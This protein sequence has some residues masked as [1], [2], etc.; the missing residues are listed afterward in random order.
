M[1]ETLLN[2]NQINPIDWVKPADWIDIRSGAL[3]NS[4]YFLVGHSADYTTYPTFTVRASVSSSGTYDVFVDGVKQASAV[5]SGTTTTLTWSTLALTTGYD[6]TY[7]AALRTHIVRVTPTSSS[8]TLTAIN[9]AEDSTYTSKG[10]L[11]IHFSITNRIE[12]SKLC[13]DEYYN[14]SRD[15]NPVLEAITAE[16]DELQI[17][18]TYGLAGAFSDCANL[19]YLPVIEGTEVVYLA[20]VHLYLTLL[21]KLSV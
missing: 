17:T 16:G 14:F 13:A 21:L 20:L 11:W 8:N 12:V 1:S 2:Q 4:V 6:V 3:T 18:G 5:A 7:P 10:T 9:K 19:K 15:K